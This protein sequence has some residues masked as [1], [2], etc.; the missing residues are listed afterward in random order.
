MSTRLFA[1]SAANPVFHAI[2]PLSMKYESSSF[3]QG[4]PT[5]NEM[6]INVDEIVKLISD[7][8]IKTFISL[9]IYND[10]D[11]SRIYI[12]LLSNTVKALLLFIIYPSSVN[13]HIF[14]LTK[15]TFSQK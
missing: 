6:T 5:L 3:Y 12:A 2:L 7:P 13:M 14:L 9:I 4:H 8:P 1:T 11:K 15:S 10:N